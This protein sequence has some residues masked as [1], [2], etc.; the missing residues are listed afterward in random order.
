[1]HPRVSLA[2]SPV[3]VVGPFALRSSPRPALFISVVGFSPRSQVNANCCA[4]V[5]GKIKHCIRKCISH[6]DEHSEKIGILLANRFLRIRAH[7]IPPEPFVP[8]D[9][10]ARS[11]RVYVQDHH[12]AGVCLKGAAVRIT[13]VPVVVV[14]GSPI[15][16]LITAPLLGVVKADVSDHIHFDVEGR[17]LLSSH[18]FCFRA[19]KCVS[20]YRQLMCSPL[21]CEKTPDHL[22]PTG[23]PSMHAGSSCR[24]GAKTRLSF[25]CFR[26]RRNIKQG[27]L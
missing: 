6:E 26:E 3:V 24:E 21:R 4:L 5:V 9:P 15:R 22:L 12:D 2:S 14:V 27:V 23:I 11:A 19:N 18:V 1:M 16:P 10:S 20:F 25:P 17:E 13:T 8:I 7:S